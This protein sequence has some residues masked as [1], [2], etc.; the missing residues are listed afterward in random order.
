MKVLHVIKLD[1][2]AAGGIERFAHELMDAQLDGGLDVHAV[3]CDTPGTKGLPPPRYGL[4]L[5]RTSTTLFYL[6]LAPSFPRVVRA[7]IARLAPDVVHVH[8]P[9]PLVLDLA[10]A[11]P[12]ATRLVVHW[13]ADIDPAGAILPIRVAYEM[14]VRRFESRLLARSAAVVATSRSYFGASPVL[15]PYAE[16]VRVVPLGLGSVPAA[17]SG[18]TWPMPGRPRVLFI[19]RAV[20]YKG[21][22]V[23]LEALSRIAGASLVAVGDGPR[24][25]S[26]QAL[27]RRLGLVDRVAFTGH[28]DEPTKRGWLE[29]SDVL[30]L[31]SLNRLESFGVVQLEAAAAGRPVVAADIPGSGVAEVARAIEGSAVFRSGDAATLAECLARYPS[32]DA[33]PSL[34]PRFRIDEVAREIAAIYDAVTSR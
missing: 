16:K 27:A 19:G 30:C 5:A 12:A 4:T 29:A 21:F 15:K 26:W 14:A 20:P 7:Q 13:Q 24:L 25:A 33:R 18:V 1:P 32:R 31:P 11:I 23:L 17:S 3:G 34:P 6:P 22:E 8:W 10:P 9:N 28:V 2:R